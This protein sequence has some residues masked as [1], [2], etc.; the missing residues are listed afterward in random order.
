M[1]CLL[2]FSL[3]WLPTHTL[4]RQPALSNFPQ[5][6]HTVRRVLST[7]KGTLPLLRPCT[8]LS[9]LYWHSGARCVV[10]VRFSESG[11]SVCLPRLLHE[12]LALGGPEIKRVREHP[13]VERTKNFSSRHRNDEAARYWFVETDTA[14]HRPSAFY[15][16]VQFSQRPH[17][18]RRKRLHVVDIHFHV[19]NLP[20]AHL[21]F[22][23]RTTASFSAQRHLE[24]LQPTCT[25]PT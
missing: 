10:G 23:R 7:P 15:Q 20:L 12:S 19:L 24:S 25:S 1:G 21:A 4:H 13:L 5:N 8:H 18:P 6:R 2:D 17:S 22:C 16:E 14:D 3:S 11:V 9:L